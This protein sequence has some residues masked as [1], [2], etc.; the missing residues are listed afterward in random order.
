[1]SSV[2]IGGSELL[3]VLKFQV[4]SPILC[5]SKT[6]AVLGRPIENHTAES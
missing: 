3:L 6:V 5:N 4:S 1:M 2:I